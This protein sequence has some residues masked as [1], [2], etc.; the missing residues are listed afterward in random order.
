MKENYEK[1]LDWLDRFI[2]RLMNLLKVIWWNQYRLY[3]WCWCWYVDSYFI[4]E[5]EL[6]TLK[7]YIELTAP[8]YKRMLIKEWE[9]KWEA[10]D[11]MKLQIKTISTGWN[12]RSRIRLVW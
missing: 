10:M 1:Y 8:K 3:G 2:K 9:D 7:I 12:T 6:A 11:K 4:N 5:K